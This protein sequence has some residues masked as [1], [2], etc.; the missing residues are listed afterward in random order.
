[1]R[2][3][4]LIVFITLLLFSCEKGSFEFT[5]TSLRLSKIDD[6]ET[7][8]FSLNISDEESSYLVSITSPDNTLT[9]EGELERAGSGDYSLPLEITKGSSFPSGEYSFKIYSSSGEEKSGSLMFLK[10]EF[11]PYVEDGILCGIMDG[12]GEIDGN[13]VEIGSPAQNG[14]TLIYQDQY[15]NSYLI[16]L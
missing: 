4:F 2:K 9:W 6:M 11:S 12:E 7:L 16:T 1:M 15:F 13:K 8:E 5:S 3:S 14:D 10:E